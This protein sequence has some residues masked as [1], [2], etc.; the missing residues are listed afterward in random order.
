M[1]NLVVWATKGPSR[2]ISSCSSLSLSR[3][4]PTVN[5]GTIQITLRRKYTTAPMSKNSVLSDSDRRSTTS[6]PASA[7]AASR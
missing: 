5:P 3:Y 4:R 7:A 2:S 6:K 1:R